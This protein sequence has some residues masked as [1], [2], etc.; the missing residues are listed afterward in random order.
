MRKH[1]AWA[2]ILFMI[3]FGAAFVQANPQSEY[4]DSGF[5]SLL[6]HAIRLE[7]SFPSV[8]PVGMAITEFEKAAR[9]TLTS[10]EANLMLGLIYQYLDRP[11][12]ALG[13]YLEFAQQHP[14]AVW[15][16][17]F[18]G[19]M[20]AEMGRLEDAKRS[21]ERTVAGAG[22]GEIFAQAYV[23]LG[24]AALEQG[25]YTQ[26]KE[27]FEKAL[28][29]AGDYFDARLGLGKALFFLEEY[30]EAIAALERAQV[31]APRS[32]SM[33]HYLALSY[34]AQGLHNQAQHA[35]ARYEELQSKD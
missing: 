18:V 16:Y 27:A 9:E 1:R 10:G 20:Y 15:I 6:Y 28:T 12:T 7:E 11:G 5:Q 35:L 17:S 23:G 29:D 24:N 19:D 32:T 22:E 33:L 30:E 14:E 13:Y 26:A 2:L 3:I 25:D 31:Q 34:E 21:Y 4:L 8:N